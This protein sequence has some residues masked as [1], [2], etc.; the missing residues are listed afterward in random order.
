MQNALRTFPVREEAA[1]A[2]FK[3][4]GG[5]DEENDEPDKYC[6]Q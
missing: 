1:K 3:K 2:H 6:G 4:S 5:F